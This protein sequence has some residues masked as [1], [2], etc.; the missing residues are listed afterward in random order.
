MDLQDQIKT[1]EEQSQFQAKKL[2]EEKDYLANQHV[3]IKYDNGGGQKGVRRNPMFDGY[4]A[5]MAT[6]LKTTE[7]L[8]ELREK[9]PKR[10]ES[11]ST[12]AS[13]RVIGKRDAI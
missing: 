8:N 13:L 3:I 10:D 6:Y 11:K 4:H 9:Q 7:Q 12:L 1:L 5:L 2:A